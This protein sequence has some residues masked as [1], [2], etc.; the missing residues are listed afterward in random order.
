MKAIIQSTLKEATRK[1]TF[2]V[3]GV[4]SVLYLIFWTLISYFYVNNVASDDFG[5]QVRS[6]VEPALIRMGLQ[7]SSMLMCLLTIM[8]GAGAIASELENGMVHAILSRPLRRSEYVF[9]KLLGLLILVVTYAS[10]LFFFLL[11]IGTLFGM[12]TITAL[13]LGQVLGSWFFY[14]L[15]PTTLL[16]VTIHGSVIMR[17]VPNGLLMIF[18]YILGNVGGMVEMIGEMLR[19]DGVISTGIFLSLAS[20]FHVLY[21]QAEN[22]LLSTSSLTGDMALAMGGLSGG[23]DAP[24]VSMY[25]YIGAYTLFFLGL[26]LRRFRK[27]DIS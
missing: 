12:D 15:V 6:V 22:V 14:V 10:A 11:L 19:N 16:C 21:K 5:L 2:V 17:V 3:M 9:G 23:G 13:S 25:V 7:F 4:V 18:V 20:P 24:S 27:M 1:K 8:L 26:A